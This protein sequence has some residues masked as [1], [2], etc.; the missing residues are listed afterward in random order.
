MYPIYTCTTQRPESSHTSRAAAGQTHTH[1]VA[2]SDVFASF[3]CY[4]VQ[5]KSPQEPSF[6]Q[7]FSLA[8]M[9]GKK[10]VKVCNDI[11]QPELSVSRCSLF[12]LLCL[13][14]VPLSLSPGTTLQLDCTKSILI[15]HS[16]TVPQLPPLI[17][18]CSP[19]L[20]HYIQGFF[21]NTFI[22]HDMFS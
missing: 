1:T 20:S 3:C 7:F 2:Y 8:S 18:V 11:M 14:P 10:P 9:V 12:S 6:T 22:S 5:P 16:A 15:H 13:S 21:T 17:C 19:T 4:L